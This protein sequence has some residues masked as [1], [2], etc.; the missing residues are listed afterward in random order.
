MNEFSTNRSLNKFKSLEVVDEFS[1]ED[2]NLQIFNNLQDGEKKKF[3]TDLAF[4]LSSPITDIENQETKFLFDTPL[5]NFDWDKLCS[6]NSAH[7][8]KFSL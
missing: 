3:F 6:S 1:L 5:H 4:T 8:G 2:L 7:A